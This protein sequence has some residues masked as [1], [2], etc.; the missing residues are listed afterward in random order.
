MP[1]SPQRNLK[2]AESACFITCFIGSRL[3]SPQRRGAGCL[4][5]C[6]D[7]RHLKFTDYAFSQAMLVMSQ[8]RVFADA[9][10]R[11]GCFRNQHSRLQVISNITH[12]TKY[13]TLSRVNNERARR[14]R[15]QAETSQAADISSTEEVASTSDS[16]ST[17]FSTGKTCTSDTSSTAMSSSL[18]LNDAPLPVVQR[19]P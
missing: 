19:Q 6:L 14:L 15:I 16:L 2:R 12:H 3:V 7:E 4:A 9:C 18:L 11:P 10:S 5:H 17:S 8:S 13:C 1:D